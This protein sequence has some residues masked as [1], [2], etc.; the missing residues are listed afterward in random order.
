MLPILLD[1]A[2]FKD[3]L[4][5][6]KGEERAHVGLQ[7]ARDPVVQ[8]RHAL[9]P[10]LPATATSNPRRATIALVYLTARRGRR[11]SRRDRA[12]RPRH[13]ADR[14]HRR[15]AVHEPRP[16]GD[17]RRTCCRAGFKAMVLTNAMKPMH[18]MKP[19]LSA[20]CSA[21]GRN[22][23]IRVSLDH[24]APDAARGA[25]AARAAGSRPST[26]WS[27]SR[28][29]LRRCSRRAAASRTR[30]RSEVRAGY[31]AAVR[32]A[33]RGDRRRTIRCAGAL[34]GDGCR[35]RRAGDHRRPA[36]AS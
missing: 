27:G 23:T 11:L 25:S 33:R 7:G 31:A 9:Q 36:G 32:R 13:P 12:R 19:A 2:K 8:H 35:G 3:A 24:Y 28:S 17:A 20:C 1:P 22:L 18:K 21:H 5:T 30:P 26:A 16:A 6:A 15:R 4:V 34:P 10:H 14:L 29:R